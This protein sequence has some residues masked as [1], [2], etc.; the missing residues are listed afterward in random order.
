[1]ELT[2]DVNSEIY[3]ISSNEKFSLLLVASL[4]LDG[5]IPTRETW[6]TDVKSLA[7]DYEYVMY[8]KVYKYD[9]VGNS[10]V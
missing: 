7:D 9:D 10:K 8:G 4:S 2:L 5:S 6:R 1:M 3:P